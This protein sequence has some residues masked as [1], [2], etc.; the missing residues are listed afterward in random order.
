MN[1]LLWY[2]IALAGLALAVRAIVR[3]RRYHM[4]FTAHGITLTISPDD[5][6]ATLETK[7]LDLDAKPF[8]SLLE[9]L[10][11]NDNEGPVGLRLL[12]AAFGHNTNLF[13]DLLGKFSLNDVFNYCVAHHL[14]KLLRYVAD[15]LPNNELQTHL[16]KPG[17]PTWAAQ[18][19]GAIGRS[20]WEAAA[21]II[22]KNKSAIAQK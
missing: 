21:K 4:A 19:I 17:L 12:A 10:K 8:P 5:T 1:S 11:T 18:E 20:T 16:A 7:Y 2:L 22:N 15:K 3:L 6:F 14:P 9:F 13:D